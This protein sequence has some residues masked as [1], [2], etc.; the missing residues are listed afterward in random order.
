[1]ALTSSSGSARGGRLVAG[2]AP[3]GQPVPMGICFPL[4]GSVSAMRT[5]STEGTVVVT[6]HNQPEAVILSADAYARRDTAP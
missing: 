6:N 2:A 4:A 3:R 5:L 1:M